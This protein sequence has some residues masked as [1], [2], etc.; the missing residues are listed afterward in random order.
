MIACSKTKLPLDFGTDPYFLEVLQA[1]DGDGAYVGVIRPDANKSSYPGSD[2]KGVGW[3][4]KGGVRH[5][6]NT[7][8][9]GVA[10]R[11]A[12]LDVLT[13]SGRGVEGWA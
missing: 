11:M 13:R 1:T 5:L 10:I 3:R 12:C 6:H 9:M 7:V 4:A 8:E 2:D